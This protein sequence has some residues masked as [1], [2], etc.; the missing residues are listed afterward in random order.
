MEGFLIMLPNK[1]L[2]LSESQWENFVINFNTPSGYAT[3]KIT[4]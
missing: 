1:S 4:W 2:F 3:I